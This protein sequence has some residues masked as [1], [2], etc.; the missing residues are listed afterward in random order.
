MWFAY[1]N[2]FDQANKVDYNFFD[3]KQTQ[4]CFYC[5]MNGSYNIFIFSF[6]Y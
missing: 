3:I 4:L 5:H 6:L 1:R 2:L